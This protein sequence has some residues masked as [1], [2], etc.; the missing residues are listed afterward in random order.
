MSGKHPLDRFPGRTPRQ[1]MRLVMHIFILFTI[2][3]VSI[4]ALL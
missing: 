4:L 1:R 3:V 2:V